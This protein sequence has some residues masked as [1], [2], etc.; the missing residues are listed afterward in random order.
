MRY[1]HVAFH[2]DEITES[3]IGA[4]CDPQYRGWMR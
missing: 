3:H 4:D 1:Y 2:P